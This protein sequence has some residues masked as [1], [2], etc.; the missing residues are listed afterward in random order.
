MET[1]YYILVA[2]SMLIVG[3]V[4]VALTLATLPGTW[5]IIIAALL[6]QWWRPETFSWWTIGIAVA[7]AA[8]GEILEFF[9]SGVGSAKAG[10]SKRAAITSIVTGLVGALFGTV[11]LPI[12]IVGTII[13]A[14]VGAGLGASIAESTKT[15]RTWRESFDVGRGAAI[16]RAWAVII[17]GG[18]AAVMALLLTAAAIIR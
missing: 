14:V 3:V 13:G 6:F 16:G 11:L 18:I 15:G 12:P 17:K 7:L 8:L 10:G 5:L 9:A 4:G 1:T 2:L